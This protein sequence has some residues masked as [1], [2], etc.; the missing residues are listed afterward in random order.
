[1]S[2]SICHRCHPGLDKYTLITYSSKMCV[3]V[4]ALIHNAYKEIS[5]ITNKL[6]INT[7]NALFSSLFTFGL[8]DLGLLVATV[9]FGLD[10]AGLG[11]AFA[12]VDGAAAFDC[13]LG[14]GFE[15][16][17]AFDGLGLG[18]DCAVPALLLV[19]G[20]A[21]ALAVS[22]ASNPIRLPVT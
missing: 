12:A 14:L 3:H 10:W 4:C 19:L 1:M 5:S 16:V 2:R 17:V 8:V 21:F 7:C 18:L 13:T 6:C 9:V 20:L 11:L 15:V 22:T